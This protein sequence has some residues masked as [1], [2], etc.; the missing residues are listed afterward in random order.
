MFLI[1]RNNFRGAV[2]LA[3]GPNLVGERLQLIF[4]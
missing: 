4:A 1:Y 3:L 2:T